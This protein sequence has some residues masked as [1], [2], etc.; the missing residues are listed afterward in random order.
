MKFIPNSTEVTDAHL[1]FAI[2]VNTGSPQPNSQCV[3][4]GIEFIPG[5]NVVTQRHFNVGQATVFVPIDWHN[6]NVGPN[7]RNRSR[8]TQARLIADSDSHPHRLFLQVRKCT[9]VIDPNA[10]SST[11]INSAGDAIPTRAKRIG[12]TVSVRPVSHQHAIVD[13]NC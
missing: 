13:T 6:S 10:A 2:L 7:C 1:Y 5:N 12:N 8:A 3:Q 11:Q 9:N 4:L